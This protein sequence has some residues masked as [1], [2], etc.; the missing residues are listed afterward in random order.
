M[1]IKNKK[2]ASLI[3]EKAIQITADLL[4]AEFEEEFKDN[5]DLA[6]EKLFKVSGLFTKEEMDT[7]LLGENRLFLY[8]ILMDNSVSEIA[9]EIRSYLS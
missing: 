5:L 9:A 3:K 2:Q 1:K 8:E 4:K 6:Y 7:I